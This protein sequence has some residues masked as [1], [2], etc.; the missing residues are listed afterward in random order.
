MIRMLLLLPGE[1]YRVTDFV[2]AASRLAGE[3]EVDLVVGSDAADALAG[4]YPGRFLPL[5]FSDPER[6]ARRIA[7]FADSAPGRDLDRVVAVDDG[8]TL[9]AA[10]AAE[11][12]GLPANPVGAVAATRDKALLRER[13][14]AAGVPSPPWWRLG[15]DDDPATLGRQIGFPCVVKPLSLSGSRGVIRADGPGAFTAAVE[16]VRRLLR[17]PE[18]VRECGGSADLLVE[19]YIPGREI[20][21][22]GLLE[23]GAA[24]TT[25][26]R[27]LAIFDKPDPLEG[28]YFEETIYVTPSRLPAREQQRAIAITERASHALGLRRGPVHAE[29]RLNDGDAW[30]VDIAA[31][32][33]GGLCARSLRFASHRPGSDEAGASLEELLLRDAV[34]GPAA[35]AGYA[36]ESSA[37]GVMMIP[38]PSAGILRSVSGAAAA[39]SVPGITGLSLTVTRGRRLVPLPE[40]GEYL[41]FLFSRAAT[42]EGAESA[43]RRAHAA[44][45]FE[46]EPDEAGM[47]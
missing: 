42:P 35:T 3:L 27:V 32:S 43:L 14:A 6:A 5:D 11:R 30:P 4:L 26:L 16:R 31:R 15:E 17:R 40:G 18:V 37:A 44:L 28:P 19:G 1:S 41:G 23:P 24:G 12:L 20:A 38:I 34:G 10:H 13:L 39:E 36:R 2:N 46:V 29:L 22:E 9:V 45:R 47:G 25:R 33:I 7:A 21:I 8:G